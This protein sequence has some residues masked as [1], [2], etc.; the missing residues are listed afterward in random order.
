MKRHLFIIGCISI[1]FLSGTANALPS[2]NI[3]SPLFFDD[4]VPVWEV[5]DS[6]TYK[7]KNFTVDYSDTSISVFL[8]GIIEDFE[9]TV[10]STGGSDYILDF[11]GKI[12]ADYTIYY[13]TGTNEIY[14]TGTF[15]PLLTRLAGT[16]VFTKSSL[17]LKD[18][19][20]QIRGITMAVIDP[21]PFA[22]P[23][24]YKLD[25]SGNLDAV[26]P[27]IDFP[28]YNG[29]T[30][31]SPSIN[32]QM[33]ATM[34]GPLGLISFPFTLTSSFPSWLI[35]CTDYTTITVQGNTYDA[36]EIE[37]IIVTMFRLYYAPAVGNLVKIDAALTNGNLHADLISTTYS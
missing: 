30:W 11:T 16:L 25:V 26:F 29:K 13:N 9:W 8:H 1:L 12:T 19:D 7:V 27:I 5:G 18:I 22:L 36:Y 23:I 3:S 20:A 17:E 6:W 35:G 4:D 2:K 21:L 34:G 33:Q 28:I 31:N 10:S 24:P 15:K 14:L 37:P 32:I